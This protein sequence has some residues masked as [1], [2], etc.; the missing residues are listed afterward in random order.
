MN[1]Y[2]IPVAFRFNG[3]LRDPCV[4]PSS[5]IILLGHVGRLPTWSQQ[6]HSQQCKYERFK[7]NERYDIVV[8]IFRRK[9]VTHDLSETR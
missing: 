8:I 1:K 9:I 7:R 6:L 2:P 5:L 3:F 4:L